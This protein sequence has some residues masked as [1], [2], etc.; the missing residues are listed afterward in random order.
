MYNF[1]FLRVDFV[2]YYSVKILLLQLILMKLGGRII[3]S[4]NLGRHSSELIEYFQVCL[5]FTTLQFP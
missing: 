5:Q 1:C 2:I 3:Y 4:G